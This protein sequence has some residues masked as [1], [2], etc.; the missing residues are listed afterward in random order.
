[1]EKETT[2]KKKTGRRKAVFV[3]R[4]EAK[5]GESDAPLAASWLM[6]PKDACLR[7]CHTACSS[8]SI[9]FAVSATA[10]PRGSAATRTGHAGSR[11]L[12]RRSDA[13]APRG[14]VDAR[15]ARTTGVLSA[16][17]PSRVPLR[18]EARSAWLIV[19]T[20]ARGLSSRPASRSRA[21][22]YANSPANNGVRE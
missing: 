5:P 20:S 21:R 18:R 2:T 8:S 13:E 17:P 3:V 22:W 9:A 11:S 6:S 7:L 16:S 10:V 4:L 14:G 19:A 12:Q 15:R 1:M